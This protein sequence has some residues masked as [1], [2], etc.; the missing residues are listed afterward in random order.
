MMNRIV[1]ERDYIDLILGGKVP[2]KEYILY[3]TTKTLHQAQTVAGYESIVTAIVAQ[4]AQGW[5]VSNREGD[6][7]RAE[8]TPL[9]AEIDIHG[10][11]GVLIK[12]IK[13]LLDALKGVAFK[14]DNCIVRLIATS[15]DDCVEYA[16]IRLTAAPPAD[17]S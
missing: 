10:T 17:A 5:T 4:G 11:P 6:M 9:R 13:C 3:G 14:D 15:I 8:N 12:Q 2:E 1:E 16:H 7:N